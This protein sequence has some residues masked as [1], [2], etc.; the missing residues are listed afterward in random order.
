MALRIIGRVAEQA[1]L[2][3]F[4]E[5]SEAE[6]VVVYGRRRVGKTFLVQ[7]YFGTS[8]VF[9][10][11]GLAEPDMGLQLR[12]F[13]DALAR[14][15]GP[16]IRP[17]ASWFEAFNAL[18]DYLSTVPRRRGRKRVVFIDEM[19]WIDTP[20][21]NFIAALEHFWNGWGASQRDLVLVVCGSATAWIVRKLLKNRAGLHNRVTGRISLGPFTLKECGDY[22]RELG[23]PYQPKQIADCYM[24]FGGVPFYLRQFTRGLSPIQ[25]I[26]RL[27]FEPG[28]PLAGEFEELYRSLFRHPGRHIT[29]VEAL[30]RKLTGLTRDE[31]VLATGLPSGG[32]LT[33]TLR[34]LEQC[35]FI[36]SYRD[37]ANLKKGLRYRIADPFTLFHF[38]HLANAP[39]GQ[40]GYWSARSGS[41]ARGAWS[42]FTF[43]LVCLVHIDQ[44]KR[45]LGIAGV[46][47]T[48]SQWRSRAD[49]GA[50]IDLVIDRH[51]QTI[52][53]CEI[54]YAGQEF[55]I[56]KSYAQTLARKARVFTAE[57][58][59]R[60][61][62]HTTLI[63][64]FGIKP[65][66]HSH[67]ADSQVTL[68]DLFT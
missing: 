7:E 10:W 14:R 28:A 38:K 30:A 66:L 55:A 9:S 33:E 5:S 3:R 27:C 16:G 51:D 53:L 11:T 46:A 56:T 24:V 63:T 67:T 41:A 21:S 19:P 47:T 58:G 36:R 8:I 6:F 20:K 29:V 25:N 40:S 59:T 42:G 34:D 54:K 32:T 48:E 49:P 52:N 12:N 68:A 62:P 50:Q 26:D 65:N 45:A 2:R 64:T 31:V 57:A 61:D 37:F 15:A 13:D 1:E 44:I 60:K 17:A 35:G 22:F 23:L 39:R 4:E 43:E 18:R